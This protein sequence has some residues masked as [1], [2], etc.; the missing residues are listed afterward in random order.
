MADLGTGAAGLQRSPS[1]HRAHA[2]ALSKIAH[3]RSG[4]EKVCPVRAERRHEPAHSLFP[5]LAQGQRGALRNETPGYGLISVLCHGEFVMRP[6]GWTPSIV[7]RNDQDVYLLADDLGRL[8]RAWR[9][10]D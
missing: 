6:S 9:E 5:R 10:A 3:V 8:G 2:P 4:C 1:P 7:P